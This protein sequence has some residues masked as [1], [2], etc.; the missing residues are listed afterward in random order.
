MRPLER[1]GKTG[2]REDSA[3][4]PKK[5]ASIETRAIGGGAHGYVENVRDGAQA[6]GP[7]RRVAAPRVELA[8]GD[9]TRNIG[10][11]SL[12]AHMAADSH[13]ALRA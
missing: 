7:G 9:N 2:S 10:A 6:V 5:L 8:G 11:R 4:E 13:A 12:G 1:G 3:S